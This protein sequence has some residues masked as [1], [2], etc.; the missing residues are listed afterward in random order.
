MKLSALFP[1]LG[2]QRDNLNEVFNNNS[3][4]S[5][6]RKPLNLYLRTAARLWG[7]LLLLTCTGIVW[8]QETATPTLTTDKADYKPGETAT[9]TGSGFQA[10]ETVTL[11]VLHADHQPGDPITGEDHDP[12]QV[13]A[14][15]NGGFVTTWH[16]CEDDC[17]GETLI[18]TA[19][20]QTSA[21]HAE[22]YF[23][24]AQI[25]INASTLW[26]AI[27]P[28]PTALDDILIRNGATL[29][30]DVAN[31][32][33]RTI[34]IGNNAIPALT[35]G[36]GTLTFQS[37]SQVTVAQGVQ[38][39]DP[40]SPVRSGTLNLVAGATLI[41]GNG[42]N[43]LQAVSN[44]SSSVN[45]S[46]GVATINGRFEIGD[47]NTATIT[48]GTISVD[49]GAIGGAN[50]VVQFNAG[51]TLTFTGGTLTVVD[52]NPNPGG[53]N[54]LQVVAGTG[55]KNL[56]GS[57]VQF[58]DGTSATAGSA[59]GFDVNAGVT[60]GNMTINNP[61]GTN[62][63]VRL[64]TN[65]ATMGGNLT[66]T[67]GELRANGFDISLA[68][69]WS[70][71]GTFTP[72]TRKVT[73]NGAAQTIGGSNATTFY[74]VDIGGTANKTL[75]NDITINNTLTL[76]NR[77]IDAYTNSKTV[78][79]KGA[80]IR[81]T[82]GHIMG[83]LKKDVPTGAITRFFEVG[84]TLYAPLEAKFSVVSTA[85]TLT[86]RTVDGDHPSINTSTLDPDNSVNRYWTVN[87]SGIVFTSCAVTLHYNDP[88]DLDAGVTPATFRVGKL[89][90]TTWTYPAIIG[91]PT[92][93]EIRAGGLNGFSDLVVASCPVPIISDQPDN[94]IR[95]LGGSAVFNIASN[96][97][98]S[99][100][101]QWY[102]ENGATD[103]ALDDEDDG[104]DIQITNSGA[105]LTINN[106][107]A[108]DAG[109]Y[110]VIVTQ[111]CGSTV[112]SAVATLAIDQ[113]APVIPTTYVSKTSL[114]PP[115][116]KMVDIALSASDGT[117]I[118]I[119]SATVTVT[120]NEPINDIGDGNTDPDISW[121]GGVQTNTSPYT[122][123]GPVT[124][125][126]DGKFHILL[127]AERSGVQALVTPDIGRIYTVTFTVTDGCGNTAGPVNN[128][129]TVAHN[130]TGPITGSSFR[131]GTVVGLAGTFWDVPGN[132][133]TAKW[134]VD[135]ATVNGTVTAEPTG[136]KLGKVTG[137]YK[138]TAAGVYKLRM[139][140]TD[141]R[142]L[143]SYATTNG[144]N[145]AFLVAYDPNG[146]YTYGAGKF[147]SPL[148]ALT[149]NP[150]A[151]G[152]VAFG[153]TSNYF[154]GATN[155]KG[156][157]QFEF[158]LAD[159]EFSALNFDYLVISGARAQYKGLGKTIVNGVEQ[160][161]IAFIL[162]VID[163]QLGG[164]GG[165]DKI[166]LKIYN[167]NT[168]A[169]IYDNQRGAS[170]NADP[171]VTVADPKANGTDIVV[172]NTAV[173]TT[174]TPVSI[175]QRTELVD[176]PTG[177]SIKA[178]INPSQRF[179]IINVFSPGSEPVELSVFDI[180]GRQVYKTRGDVKQNFQFGETLAGG[181]Y[182]VEAV[183]GAKRSMLKL[184]KQ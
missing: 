116:H 25:Q 88:D 38:V 138:P 51:A 168:G 20:G 165:T 173:T 104:G 99:K 134:Q 170:D 184:I 128:T 121:T 66:I 40:G 9:L 86:V 176:V 156:E 71:S 44:T 133:H 131:I 35:A 87:N 90:G 169:V 19:D 110:Y 117:G 41:L 122:V 107:A 163:G 154:K 98:G 62:R 56:A 129:V 166:R 64:V 84:Q 97:V 144:D 179:F 171:V 167:K 31:A 21:R 4:G 180:Y 14:D 59:E 162:T 2:F 157:T 65:H 60:L 181:T 177:F 155:P 140:V 39:G 112:T 105:T 8:A 172:V 143:T 139:N 125:G 23:T 93:I 102:K 54:A 82:T 79:A 153:F 123:T 10:G 78:Y 101:Y 83:N 81:T 34:R 137:S 53:G 141:Q 119:T 152:K 80:V 182:F 75:G 52:P 147:I 164:G 183:Q 175:E 95:C 33:C 72:G 16:V 91:T 42:T 47:G 22:I 67:A 15:E 28:V 161:G 63:F 151:G 106:L 12:W 132:R 3:A 113:T 30:V 5:L 149:S 11:Q 50:H 136:N 29:T 160:S 27:V 115:N 77:N 13:T 7:L 37:G 92:T 158:K 94:I 146:G 26:S 76:L 145:E 17:L 70:N 48:G 32:V 18:A 43:A 73:F 36:N 142:G 159:F 96:A 45:I 57:T 1:L 49:P 24:D 130:I 124:V 135:G 174:T 61:S 118:G 6:L 89:D 46:G 178:R 108:S 58:G 68:G 148:G 74:D 55:T 109:S 100:A 103:I 85:G 111:D 69:N 114:W 150:N 120:S 126:T 127:R